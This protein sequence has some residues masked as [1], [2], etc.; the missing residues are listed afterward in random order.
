M[1][2]LCLFSVARTV[3]QRYGDSANENQTCEVHLSRWPSKRRG[4]LKSLK[5]NADQIALLR[6][7]SKTKSKELL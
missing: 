3:L 5:V 2:P 1:K 4:F 6:F 7:S